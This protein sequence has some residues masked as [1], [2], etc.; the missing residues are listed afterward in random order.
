MALTPDQVKAHFDTI[1]AA[2]PDMRR[3]ADSD[4]FQGWVER[5]PPMVKEAVQSG[6]ASDVI[7]VLNRYKLAVG[8]VRAKPRFTSKQIENM[9]VEEFQRREKEIDEAMKAGLVT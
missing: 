2:H 1:A 5:Q 3:I 9:S 7:E 8:M 6:T 4:D